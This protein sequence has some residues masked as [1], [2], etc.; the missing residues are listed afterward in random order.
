MLGLIKRHFF[1]WLT[2]TQVSENDPFPAYD[3]GRNSATRLVEKQTNKAM[4]MR[5][6]F[7]W[8]FGTVAGS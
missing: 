8:H 3:H 7:L 2:K 1:S 4:S 5:E 6:L